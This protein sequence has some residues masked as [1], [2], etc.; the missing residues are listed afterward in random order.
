MGEEEYDPRQ[1]K[2]CNADEKSKGHVP[3]SQSYL[4]VSLS[5]GNACTLSCAA[6]IHRSQAYPLLRNRG[7]RLTAGFHRSFSL[8]HWYESLAVVKKEVPDL[9]I[10]RDLPPSM[11]SPQNSPP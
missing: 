11:T 1:D 10:L 7:Y 6:S 2:C 4:G 5:S 9:R 3:M 8:A